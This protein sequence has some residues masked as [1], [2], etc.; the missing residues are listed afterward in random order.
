MTDTGICE[1][2]TG[3]GP[4][5]ILDSR[6]AVA[7]SQ[8]FLLLAQLARVVLFLLVTR[9]LGRAMSPAD[10]GFFALV[11]TMFVLALEVM[12]MG[13]TAVV[14]RQVAQQPWMERELLEAL[15]GWRRLVALVM[16]L[17]CLLLA[18]FG[19]ARSAN[20]TVVL[21]AAALGLFLLHQSSYYVVF[22]LRQAY[23]KPLML[24]LGA[25]VTFLVASLL[26]LR[27]HGVGILVALLVVVREIVQ[28]LG[29]R[30]IAIRALGFRLQ[31]RILSPALRP[32]LRKAW[33]FGLCAVMY[34]L[35][36][37]G[38]TFFVWIFESPEV[39][40]AFSA[41]L[42]LFSPVID[43][44]WLFVTPLI[45]GMSVVAGSDAGAFRE[46]LA[47]YLSML[48]GVA[49][50]LAVCG[51]FLAPT[52]LSMLYGDR[53]VL[54][55]LSTVV[56]FRWLSAAI[57]LALITPVA[58]IAL[59]A[60]HREKDL[61]RI[62]AAG[63]GLNILL[64]VWAIPRHGAAGAAMA[65]FATETFILFGTLIRLRASGDW[66]PSPNLAAYLVPAAVLAMSLQALEEHAQLRLPLAGL[67]GT[68]SVLVMWHLP[69][70]KKNRLGFNVATALLARSSSTPRDWP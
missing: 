66:L 58:V 44:A 9:Q 42:R 53:Y 25:Q 68:L 37:H 52:V 70:Q 1:P 23:G 32:L 34:K 63:L 26:L 21:V 49:G 27:L 33:P 11:S 6:P 24:G 18:L 20:A 45:V 57:A 56:T 55:A 30:L 43:A 35:T 19:P 22:Q 41:S 3:G 59:L 39:L 28:V 54:G 67:F 46:Q 60:Q 64:C 62:S 51:Y 31:S 14:T 4:D 48:L 2:G 13:S 16:A 12:D 61:L 29:S 69:S 8:A 65:T 50:L 36:F 38:G 7:R 5:P 40:G 15:L 10:F 47:A 17:G